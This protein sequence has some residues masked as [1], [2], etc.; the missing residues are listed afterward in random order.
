MKK[1][2]VNLIILLPIIFFISCGGSSSENISNSKKGVFIDDVVV[3]LKYKTAGLTGY[4]NSKGE[5]A[6]LNKT[7]EFY[8]GNIKIGEI[9]SLPS[10]NNVF[11]QDLFNLDR[12][13]L[14]DSRVI[15]I[16]TFLQSIDTNENTD[17][18]ELSNITMS[19]FHNING[20]LLNKDISNLLSERDYKEKNLN[21]VKEHLIKSYNKKNTALFDKTEKDFLYE[22]LTQ[23]YFWSDKVPNTSYEH[24]TDPN[25]MI[26]DF[27]YSTLDKWSYAETFEKFYKD[28]AQSSDGF[29]C[30]F[31]GT[32]YI[33]NIK[34]NSPCDLVGLKR[35]D[36]LIKIDDKTITNESYNAARLNYGV[37]VT[38]TI[39]RNA[40]E[41]KVK[42]TP[43]NYIYKVSKYSFIT[44]GEKK[45]GYFI[46][47]SFSS[48]GTVEIDEA[49]TYFKNKN[50]DEL[51]IDLR[52]N[53]GGSLNTAS[54][55]LDKIAAYNHA[56]K[57]QYKEI[58][59]PTGQEDIELFIKA[60][61]SINL[62][63]VFFLTSNNTASASEL[64]INSLRPHMNVKLIGKT[65]SGKPV[66]MTGQYNSSKYIY[67]LINL[68]MYNANGVGEYFE[69]L[70]V[71][72]DLDDNKSIPLFDE[73]ENLL[74]EALYYI[75]N[76]SC[77]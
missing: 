23:R 73:N 17:E 27:R 2:L 41:I 72:C 43:N 44:V 3:G 21:D 46:F 19:K 13:N 11:I 64:V 29:G 35:G 38:F 5:F 63:R 76:G 55:M 58:Y 50:I 77:S 10:D 40:E 67:W 48:L 56:G 37:E 54:Y 68:S 15:K 34:F 52:Y 25:N 20:E 9:N 69:G 60:D 28:S 24:Y 4:T 70:N 18:I 22:S 61:N 16:A 65:T 6:Y 1:I 74:K 75:E 14:S 71:D 26:K 12:A 30:I 42:I 31:N 45:I 39:E 33:Y 53:G 8:V 66:G 7:V 62:S 49:F 36:K 47:N 57:V 59:T 32:P 51:I